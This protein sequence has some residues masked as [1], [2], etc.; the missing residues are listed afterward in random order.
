MGKNLRDV[1]R[2]AETAKR[3]ARAKA[4]KEKQGRQK[5]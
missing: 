5:K 3:E 2:P 1:N 4:I